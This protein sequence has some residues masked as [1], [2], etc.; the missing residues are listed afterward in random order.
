MTMLSRHL[1]ALPHRRTRPDRHANKLHHNLVRSTASAAKRIRVTQCGQPG[2]RF[3]VTTMVTE[4]ST[5][6]STTLPFV[7]AHSRR[8]RS[9]PLECHLPVHAHVQRQILRAAAWQ[10]QREDEPIGGDIVRIEVKCGRVGKPRYDRRR[11][12]DLDGGGGRLTWT[13]ISRP[14]AARY[15]RVRPSRP[16][17]G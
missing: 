10:R 16:Q 17:R 11:R 6:P 1:V 13:L 12:A 15:I 3:L 7:P 8:V 9:D 2:D 5:E 14:S 4:R